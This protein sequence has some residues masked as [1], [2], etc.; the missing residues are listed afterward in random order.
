MISPRPEGEGEEQPPEGAHLREASM[1]E[2]PDAGKLHV[3]DVG[4]GRVTGIPAAE[5]AKAY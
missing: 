5:Y 2:E 4:W 3:R 1:T